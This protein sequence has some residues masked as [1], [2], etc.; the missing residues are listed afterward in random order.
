MTGAHVDGDGLDPVIFEV[1]DM[2]RED[3]A[4]HPTACPD[5]GKP[6]GVHPHSR[7]CPRSPLRVLD[8]PSPDDDGHDPDL[9]VP[10]PWLMTGGGQ[11]A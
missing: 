4:A 9:A 1:L 3:A 5:C 7:E 6:Y 2:F 10:D 11:V 8:V